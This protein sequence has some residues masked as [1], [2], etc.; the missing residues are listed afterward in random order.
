MFCRYADDCNVYVKS[1]A[2]GKRV[3]NS[4]ASFLEKNSSFASTVR[5]ARWQCPMSVSSWD[6]VY[7]EEER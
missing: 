7:C 3:M 6:T 1:K 4:I 2:A 5:R